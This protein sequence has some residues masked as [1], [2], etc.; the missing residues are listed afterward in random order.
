MDDVIIIGGSFAGLAGALQLSRLAHVEF[1]AFWTH[2]RCSG[3][4]SISQVIE[5]LSRQRV[6]IPPE[7]FDRFLPGQMDFLQGASDFAAEQAARDG[8]HQR[9]AG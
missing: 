4:A 8:P 6:P 2:C 7:A 1:F 9:R 5:A 3:E